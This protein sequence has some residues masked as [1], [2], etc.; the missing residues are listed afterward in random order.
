MFP[1]L[2]TRGDNTGGLSQSQRCDCVLIARKKYSVALTNAA[3]SARYS[4]FVTK[5]SPSLKIWRAPDVFY[6]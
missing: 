4:P 3:F 5:N 6:S 1:R 2:C